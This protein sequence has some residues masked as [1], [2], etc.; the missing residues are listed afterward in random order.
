M[1]S[2]TP[3]V[4]V[5]VP[6]YKRSDTLVKAITSVLAQTYQNVEVLVIDDNNPDTE[7]RH[8]TAKKMAA[9]QNYPNVK[10]IQHSKNK[11]GSAA[12]NTG[13]KNAKGEYFCFLD[14]DDCYFPEKI[15]RQIR[16]MIDNCSDACFCD[17]IKNGKP[18]FVDE[19]SDFVRNVFLELPTPQ[20]SGW[21]IS[22]K[23]VQ[24]LNGF[25]ESYYR[26]QDYEFL[27][28]LYKAGFTMG[29]VNEVLYERNST[30]IDNNP[31]G[32]KTELI[33]E[34]LFSDFDDIIKVCEQ[35]DRGFEKDLKISAKVSAFK[36]YYKNRDIV[37]CIRLF[38]ECCVIS[39]PKTFIEY[40][41]VIKSHI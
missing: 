3:L 5:I 17:Y 18:V 30:Q 2:E 39:I 36:N 13:I 26:H 34:K 9:F 35:R 4:S 37:N 32:E 15:E 1:N 24:R 14:D 11:N 12:R 19:K 33:K 29:K 23:V 7:W 27:L 16:Y 28:R 22:K 10:Y 25:D 41:K 6:T 40:I 21:L 38:V 20:T 31:S 8:I